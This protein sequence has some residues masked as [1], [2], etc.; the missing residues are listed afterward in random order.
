MQGVT[1]AVEKLHGMQCYMPGALVQFHYRT[2]KIFLRRDSAS[3]LHLRSSH[4]CAA[5]ASDTEFALCNA[6]L[7]C[8]PGESEALS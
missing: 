3:L 8:R 4:S 1:A 6:R 7:I 5:G 2:W